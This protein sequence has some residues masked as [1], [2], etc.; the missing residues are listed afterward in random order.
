MFR[1]CVVF[2]AFLI[3]SASYLVAQ[4]T[5]A[6]PLE[7]QVTTAQ[8]WTDTGLDLQSGDV[9]NISATSSISSEKHTA[10]TAPVCD[11]AGLS[12]AASSGSLPLP[13]AA[14]GA[15]IARLNQGSTPVLIGAS[16]ELHINEASHLFLGMNISGTPPCQGSFTVKVQKN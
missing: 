5:S 16:N 4:S 1:V 12:G 13:S 8:A 14:P 10:S 11:P 7:F 6:S 2:L 15:L 9:V 3:P